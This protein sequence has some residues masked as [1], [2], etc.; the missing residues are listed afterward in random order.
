MGRDGRS[1]T[2]YK[3]RTMVPDAEARRKQLVALNETDAVLFKI[4]NDPRITRL[5]ARL[6]RWSVDELPQ[7]INVLL[8]DMS[9]VGPAA[10]AARRRR[11]YIATTSVAD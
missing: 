11:R 2:L 9:L 4:R 8:G 3:F 5:G 10:R 1:F 7:L 6:R